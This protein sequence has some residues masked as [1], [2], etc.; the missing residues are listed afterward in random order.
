MNL[1]GLTWRIGNDAEGES[2]RQ[3]NTSLSDDAWQLKYV[4][5]VNLVLQFC[6]SSQ[7]PAARA[8]AQPNKPTTTTPQIPNQGA[9]S[10]NMEQE[11]RLRMLSRRSQSRS[12]Y[13]ISGRRT[14]AL[15]NFPT[16]TAPMASWL[17]SLKFVSPN[18]LQP[19]TSAKKHWAKSMWKD[20]GCP[21]AARRCATGSRC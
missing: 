17:P 11:K 12:I 9:P 8:T 2:S 4:V 19:K 16:M 13:R 18:L 21:A 3:L 6:A 15:F 7:T 10:K 20:G 14:P 1:G 5:Q